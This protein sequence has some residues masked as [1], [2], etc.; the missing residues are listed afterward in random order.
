MFQAAQHQ[1]VPEPLP[2]FIECDERAAR[3]RALARTACAAEG[4]V[5]TFVPLVLGQLGDMQYKRPAVLFQVTLTT[6]ATTMV[7]PILEGQEPDS[8]ARWYCHDSE[9]DPVE[10]RRAIQRATYDPLQQQLDQRGR[11][12]WI[13]RGA[14]KHACVQSLASGN[15][16]FCHANTVV[17]GHVAS[18]YLPLCRR[19]ERAADEMSSPGSAPRPPPIVASAVPSEV[20]AEHVRAEGGSVHHGNISG[21]GGQQVPGSCDEAG[22][23]SSNESTDEDSDS[24]IQWWGGGIA[25]TVAVDAVCNQ[26]LATSTTLASDRGASLELGAI[27]IGRCRTAVHKAV[28]EH[29]V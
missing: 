27:A 5:E 20:Q 19:N 24:G 6:L 13:C 11:E 2:T 22:L 18:A 4:G 1:Q 23:A 7:V 8:I 3:A 16:I 29:R 28:R 12:G 15:R 10:C 14:H 17:T 26:Y 25:K 9:E 21:S